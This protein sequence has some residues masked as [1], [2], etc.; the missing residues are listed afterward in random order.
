MDES[1]RILNQLAQIETFESRIDE[2]YKLSGESLDVLQINVGRLCNLACRHCH[3]EAGP[4]RREIMGREV[5]SACLKVC[6]EQKVKTVDI[7]GGAPEMNPNFQWFVGELCK[8]CS[9][10]I[11][12]SNL[13]ILT[14]EGY[15]HLPEFFAT[16]KIEVAA[17]LPYYREK[18]MDRVR[19]NGSFTASIKVLQRLNLLGYGKGKGLVLSLVYNPAGAFFPPAQSAL[20]KEYKAKLLSDYG[21]VFDHLLTITNNPTGRFFNFLVRSD[22]LEDY[23]NKLYSAFNRATLHRLMCRYQLS[24]GYDG[25]LYDCDFNQAAGLPVSTGE[26]IFDLAEGSYR[27]RRLCFG[28]HCY[29]CTAGQGSSCGGATEN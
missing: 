26:S 22:N 27:S 28:N 10:V 20:E 25:R 13:V 6:R 19:G 29:G 15:E 3:V 5:L 7:T 24:V 9:H 12:R 14:E 8:I 1:I 4:E 16:H 17:S 11:V 18:E 21:I 2:A 23:M